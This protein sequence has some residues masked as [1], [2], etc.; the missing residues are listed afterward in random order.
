MGARPTSSF[1][2]NHLCLFVCLCVYNWAG[3]IPTQ[4]IYTNTRT[5][6]AA[7]S[8][9]LDF[10]VF[11]LYNFSFYNFLLDVVRITIRATE[12]T[13]NDNNNTPFFTFLFVYYSARV[14]CEWCVLFF[15]LMDCVPIKCMLNDCEYRVYRYRQHRAAT[16]RFNDMFI[17][18]NNTPASHTHTHSAIEYGK[19]RWRRRRQRQRCI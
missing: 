13:T 7:C 19:W 11:F 14:L 4:R 15:F 5:P 9:R 17:I 1:I 10:A 3:T 2:A 8:V 6:S 12:M 16:K 18:I